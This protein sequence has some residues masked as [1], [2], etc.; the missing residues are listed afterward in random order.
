MPITCP[1]LKLGAPD[2]AWQQFQM[3]L[4]DDDNDFGYV[5]VEVDSDDNGDHNIDDEHDVENQTGDFSASFKA[6]SSRFFMVLDLYNTN[7]Y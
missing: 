2:F 4:T 7:R 6:R 3:I 1:F 5:N